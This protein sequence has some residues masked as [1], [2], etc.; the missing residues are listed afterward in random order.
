M[1]ILLLAKQTRLK[2]PSA[3]DLRKRILNGGFGVQ[4]VQP[5]Q[6]VEHVLGRTSLIWL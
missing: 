6:P 4:P 5:V 2:L 1:E 3:L